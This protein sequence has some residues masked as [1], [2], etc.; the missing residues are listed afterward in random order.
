MI[1]NGKEGHLYW[2]RAS[3]PHWVGVEDATEFTDSEKGMIDGG[4]VVPGEWVELWSCDGCGENMPC[5]TGEGRT[6]PFTRQSID[7]PETV[8]IC[9]VCVG[10]REAAEETRA[11][12]LRE[13]YYE[14][15]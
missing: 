6:A 15:K 10:N 13:Q 4:D 9:E 14:L 12:A 1:R 2:R 5:D 8:W 7:P 3:L 11:E